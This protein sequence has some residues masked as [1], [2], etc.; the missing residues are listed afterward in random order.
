MQLYGKGESDS[1]AAGTPFEELVYEHTDVTLSHWHATW[2]VHVKET[3]APWFHL[4][5]RDLTG[6]LLFLASL[7]G[8][9]AYF[10]LR[11]RRK[12]QI[13]A[14]PDH[15]PLPGQDLDEEL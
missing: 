14:L 5:L 1:P 10:F 9:I 8:L 11:R 2:Q 4:L 15:P 6:T 7:I 13:A 3:A 12:R